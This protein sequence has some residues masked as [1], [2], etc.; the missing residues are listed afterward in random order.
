MFQPCTCTWR[1]AQVRPLSLS[2]LVCLH[3]VVVD[4][5]TLWNA[6]PTH[7][8]ASWLKKRNSAHPSI[9]FCQLGSG[10]SWKPSTGNLFVWRRNW[11]RLRVKC[12]RSA[13]HC[14]TFARTTT[15]M[16]GSGS[17]HKRIT[18]QLFSLEPKIQCK[19]HMC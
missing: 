15:A 9:L 18:A 5:R 19:S 4:V 17:Q 14:E 10:A 16:S 6:R 2:S 8:P 7:A 13:M 12:K 1:F 3:T 11:K